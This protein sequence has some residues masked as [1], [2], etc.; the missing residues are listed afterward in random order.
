MNKYFLKSDNKE[1]KIGEK[2]QLKMPINTSYGEAEAIAE[3]EV[4]EKTLAQL[5]EDGFVEVKEEKSREELTYDKLLPY[6]HR[7]VVRKDL[8]VYSDLALS[9]FSILR[10]ISP[11]A[12]I[13]LA[14]DVIA[15][16]KNRGKQNPMKEYFYCDPEHD[17]K[18]C[19]S[20]GEP[21][22][23]VFYR[24]SDA[25]HAYTML[26]PLIAALKNEE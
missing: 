9:L 19:T 7:A 10:S 20:Y 12:F 26:K 5:V 1:I 4:N 11:K 16:E 24:D 18:P 21:F 23:P 15:Q 6:F 2:I 17:Y 22:L 13:T 3:I 14:F 25:W 8:G